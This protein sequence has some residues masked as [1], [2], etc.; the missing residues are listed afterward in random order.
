[1]RSLLLLLLLALSACSSTAENKPSPPPIVAAGTPVELRVMVD[2]GGTTF[3][4]KA[5]A[6]YQVGPVAL[7]LARFTK[8][9]AGF[10]EAGGHHVQL[11]LPSDDA[12]KFAKFTEENVGKRIA[13]VV[14]NMVVTAPTLQS[15]I[16]GGSIEISG[17]FTAADAGTIADTIRRG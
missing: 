8:I 9:E 2:S 7:V 16:T 5:G 13:F 11:E 3:K 10:A 6:D 12:A 17:G 1:M 14:K 4:D 15:A